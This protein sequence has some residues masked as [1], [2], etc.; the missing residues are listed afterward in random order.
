MPRGQRKE[1]QYEGKALKI[2]EQIIQTE[3]KLKTLKSE[4]KAAHKE[5]LRAKKEADKKS[6]Q[7]NQKKI[8]DAIKKSGKTADEILSLLGVQSP[9]KAK[10]LDKPEVE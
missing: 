4:L 1:V 2:Y 6:A 5:Q 10:D 8:L 7:V 3:E 9:D